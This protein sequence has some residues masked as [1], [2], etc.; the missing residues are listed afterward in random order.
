MQSMT[1][2]MSKAGQTLLNDV[3]AIKAG[4]P[5]KI[6]VKTPNAET[7]EAFHQARFGEGLTEYANLESLRARHS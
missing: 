2:K 3:Q 7:M 5:A 1:G 6:F 4:A